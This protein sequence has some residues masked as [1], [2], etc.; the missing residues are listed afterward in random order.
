MTAPISIV[1][2]PS[3][4]VA[5]V[6]MS[7]LGNT[8]FSSG[9]ATLPQ[10]PSFAAVIAAALGPFGVTQLLSL[11]QAN[12][13]ALAQP[14]ATTLREPPAR[15]R[16]TTKVTRYPARRHR[17]TSK[18]RLALEAVYTDTTAQPSPAILNDLAKAIGMSRQRVQIWFR[19]QR[20]RDRATDRKRQL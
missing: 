16:A 17:T 11:A 18:Q 8:V 3:F 2:L 6:G 13:P 19:N 15:P 10:L 14:R 20:A 1:V 4:R 12:K 5:F 7:P 9:V